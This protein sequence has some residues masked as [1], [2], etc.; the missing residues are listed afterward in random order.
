ML[1]VGLQ[2]SINHISYIM[3]IIYSVVASSVVD[4]GLE[5]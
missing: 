2:V 1:K 3:V 4:H 5:T